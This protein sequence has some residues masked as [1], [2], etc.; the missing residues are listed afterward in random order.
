M[1]ILMKIMLI[2]LM[3]F[4]YGAGR[5]RKDVKELKREI[6]GFDQINNINEPRDNSSNSGSG[7]STS[8][9]I[10]QRLLDT[11]KGYDNALDKVRMKAA[12]IRDNIMEWI[13]FTK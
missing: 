8:G 6:F 4:L 7:Y 9:R 3:M 1:L 2:H 13:E 12:E 10:G 5:A 11:I